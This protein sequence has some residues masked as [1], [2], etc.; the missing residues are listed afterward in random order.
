MAEY[1]KD[2]FGNG[3]GDYSIPRIA[4]DKKMFE[5]PSEL[6][7]LFE[8]H[9][10]DDELPYLGHPDSVLLKNGDILT[11]FPSGHGKGAVR[12]KISHDGG[13]TYPDSIEN[14]PESWKNS[15][16]TPTIYRLEFSDG[17]PDKLLLVCGNPD[18]HDGLGSTGGFNCSISEDEGKTWSEFELFYGK[19]EGYN[20]IT[21]VAL[22]SLT[23]LKENGVFADKW[24][25]LFHDSDYVNYKT[26]LTFENGKMKWS[27]P[28]PYLSEYRDLEKNAGI[29]E[30]ECIRSERGKGDRLCLITRCNLKTY[31]SFLIF[32]D[33]EGRTWSRPVLAPSSL[34]GERHKADYAPD[35]RLFIDFRSIERDYKKLCRYD[36]D[37]KRNWFSEGWVGWVGTFEDLENG[38][39]GQYR[40][41]LA[42]TYLD[43][44][45][46]PEIAADADTG[47]CGHAVLDDGTIV[48]CTY[49]KF[50]NCNTSRKTYVVSKRFKLED[51]DKLYELLKE[52]G[53]GHGY[54]K[55]M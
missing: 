5:V 49:G 8:Q 22:A 19:D 9:T 15:R 37:S 21:V 14:A 32:S 55:N 27:E 12:S 1:R 26:I 4:L 44:Q 34:N 7:Y 30:V 42:H 40:L 2:L 25:G 20:F 3:A 18:W 52:N 24:M 17:T 38:N 28:V 36:P 13:V 51:I 35:G 39:E 33:D 11:V 31:N 10:V 54:G 50:D 43:N 47:Y 45:T 23:R 41:K 48:T 16:E 53:K 46:S 6:D 29:C